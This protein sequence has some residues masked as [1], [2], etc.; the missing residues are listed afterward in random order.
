TLLSTPLLAAVSNNALNFASGTDQGWSTGDAIVFGGATD[1]AGNTIT[2]STVDPNGVSGSLQRGQT[3]YAIV[4]P[5]NPSIVQLA[6]TLPNA[7]SFRPLQLSSTS[8]NVLA[9]L[10]APVPANVSP[11]ITDQPSVLVDFG[12]L[13][14]TPALSGS[15]HTLSP[16]QAGAVNVTAKLFSYE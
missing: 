3:Y 4:D 11:F 9:T 7:Q 12:A 1:L 2:I 13:D 14:L 6:H 15:A 16:V 10:L 8:L 5:A